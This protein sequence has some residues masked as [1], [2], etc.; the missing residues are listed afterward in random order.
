V[1]IILKLSVIEL[2]ICSMRWAW[3]AVSLQNLCDG[4]RRTA[5]NGGYLSSY[6]L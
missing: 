4:Q 2:L 6:R 5:R 1:I 3:A